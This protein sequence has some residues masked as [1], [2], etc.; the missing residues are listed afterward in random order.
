MRAFALTFVLLFHAFRFPAGGYISLDLFFVISGFLITGLLLHEQERKGRISIP[1]FYARRVR[2]ILP[3]SALV[4]VTTVFA[5]YYVLGFVAGNSVAD[6]AK[7]TAIFSAN[8]HFGMVGTNYL[9]SQLPPSPLQHMWSLGVEEQFYVLW[10]GLFFLIILLVGGARHR[11]ALG[12]VLALIVGASYSWSIVQTMSNAEWAYFSPFTRGGG[13]AVG[14]LLAVM[15]PKLSG[16]RPAWLC[17][18]LII[19]AVVVLI[20]ASARITESTPYPG[21]AVAIPLVCGAVMIGVGCSNPRTSFGRLLSLRPVQWM[22]AR[23][24]SLYLWHWPI[25]II[26]AE[27]AGH[28]LSAWQ[29]AGLLFAAFIASAVT[30]RFVE[31]PV[32]HA[33][34]LAS[35]TGL[36]LAIGAVLIVSTIAAAQWQIATHFGTWNPFA[37]ADFQ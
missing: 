13:L 14:A 11:F 3:A 2:R 4:V 37:T 34:V 8:I 16:L 35:R 9:G 5:T 12:T 28:D 26:P 24:Y 19:S 27:Y 20:V 6:D 21:S 23:S 17:E 33:R 32:R 31:N 1:R 18:V 36:T 22:G 30:Y 10:P 29:N 15:A 7:W 25:L